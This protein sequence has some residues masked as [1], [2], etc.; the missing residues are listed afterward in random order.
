[1]MWGFFWPQVLLFNPPGWL[2]QNLTFPVAAGATYST[3]K[4]LEM[5]NS[6]LASL[7]IEELPRQQVQ[8]KHI[9]DGPPCSLCSK[10]HYIKCSMNVF[11]LYKLFG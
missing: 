2:G 4:Y 1:M 11:Q 10:L 8:E 3:D 5:S 7:E 9:I 6:G